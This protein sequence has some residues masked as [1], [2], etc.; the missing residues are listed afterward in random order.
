M[1]GTMRRENLFEQPLL[2]MCK[3]NFLFEKLSRLDGALAMV[4]SQ[5][6]LTPLVK[7]EM[8]CCSLA[9]AHLVV[10]HCMIH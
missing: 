9:A 7:K 6:E 10:C 1:H 5:K 2:A 4:D 3:F 8:N